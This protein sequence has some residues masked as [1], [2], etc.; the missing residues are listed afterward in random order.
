MTPM[1]FPVMSTHGLVMSFDCL[2]LGVDNVTLGGCRQHEDHSKELAESDSKAIWQRATT[3]MPSL[4]KSRVVRE[5]VGI[6]PH[7]S[8]V[9]VEVEVM[10]LKNGEHLSVV[11]HYGH[12]GY[13]V[14]VSPGTAITAS[15]LAGKIL[16][17]R[18][19]EI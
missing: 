16:H 3:L 2:H 8:E 7:G 18:R 11:H 1:S 10:R 14:M 17:Q 15:K 12:C 4:K 5:D 9:R 13:G 19:Q 6:W